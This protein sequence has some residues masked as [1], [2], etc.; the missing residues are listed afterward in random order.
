MALYET[1][2]KVSANI[3]WTP[4]DFLK[5]IGN[6]AAECTATTGGD[7]TISQISSQLNTAV[8]K[9]VP[10]LMSLGFALAICFFIVQLIE[11]TMSERLTFEL[12]MKSFV[13][14]GISLGLIELSPTIY[15]KL[16]EFASAFSSDI[17]SSGFTIA[18][19]GKWGGDPSILANIM[20]NMCESE[21][22]TLWLS[23]LSI[24]LLVGLVSLLTSA[25]LVV[26]IYVICITR[27]I[28]LSIRGCLLPIAF[29]LLADDGWRGAGGRYIRKFTAVA[30]QGAVLALIGKITGGCIE[31][32]STGMLDKITN[33]NTTLSSLL[34]SVCMG[35]ALVIGVGV[36]SV[37]AMFKSNQVISDAFGA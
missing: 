3:L 31:I 18:S 17:A 4:I 26:V 24:G 11:L 16:T 2:C 25:G 33:L 30:A 36:A 1:M 32:A 19:T 23:F 22:K 9:F 35:L 15:T 12:F 13:K 37:A 28:E 29:A 8:T 14:V 27:L 10:T 6:I 5:G 34:C 20:I 21:G 7:S